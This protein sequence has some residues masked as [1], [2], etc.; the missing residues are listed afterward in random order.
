MK[1]FKII[2]SFVWEFPQMILAGMIFIFIK[3]N[4]TGREVF[5]RSIIL[6]IEGFPGGIS[7]GRFIMLNNRY[8]DDD[9]S[10]KHEY[11]H[12]I[13]SLILGWLYLPFIGLPSI[14]RA[15]IWKAGNRDS[16]SYYLGYPEN[17]ANRLGFRR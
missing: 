1:L 9:L 14:I 6:Y 13:Q 5:K 15:V 3:N 8:I 16:K 10:K 2:L 7:M 11:G 4:I 17:W 12:S